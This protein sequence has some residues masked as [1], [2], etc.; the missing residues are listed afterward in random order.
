MNS[1]RIGLFTD[2]YYPETNGVATSV[3]QLKKELELLGHDVYVFTVSNPKQKEKEPHVYRM[4]SIPFVLLK[5]RRVSCAFAK[6]WYRKIKALHL[7]V[8]HTQTEFL[9]GH[10]GRRAAEKF[11]IPLVHTYHTLYEDYT[12]Y[13]RIPGNERLKGVVRLLSRICL[14]RAD[15]V[16]VPTEKVQKIVRGYGVNKE[17]IVQ[18]TGIQLGKFGRPDWNEVHA[19]KEK[20][21]IKPG[22]HI[23]LCI[24]RLS[25]EKN[26]AEILHFLKKVI[27]TDRDVR[28][29]LVGDCPERANLEQIV[30]ESGLKSYVTFTG[31]EPWSQIQNYYALGDVFVSASRSETQGLTYVEALASGKPLLVRKDDCLN[32]LLMDGVNGYAYEDEK[33][34]LDGYQKLFDTQEGFTEVQIRESA[35]K[36]SSEA[37]GANIER[38]YQNVIEQYREKRMEGYERDAETHPMAG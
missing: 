30:E 22:Q 20:Y 11:H 29:L 33:E 9:V 7:N 31:E 8:I 24:G 38:I 15:T 10:M 34:F 5:E 26:I 21:G 12:H 37:F 2:T 36:L 23:L 27:D 6:K 25:Q 16:I 4:P 3:F 14:N 32:G 18:P 13:L 17:I 1:M 19:L 35:Q 28:L